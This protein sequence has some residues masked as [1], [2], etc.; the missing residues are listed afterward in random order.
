MNSVIKET[1][2]TSLDP[3]LY[4]FYQFYCKDY[5]SLNDMEMKEDEKW[6]KVFI[7]YLKGCKTY[8]IKNLNKFT[9]IIENGIM[10]LENRLILIKALSFEFFKDIDFA[11]FKL[12][13]MRTIMMI[14]FCIKYHDF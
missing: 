8:R 3:N 1:G 13:H 5:Q 7:Y 10:K 12:F 6:I 11:N 9:F 14:K 4:I 2:E